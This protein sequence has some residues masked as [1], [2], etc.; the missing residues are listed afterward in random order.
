LE[1]IILLIMDLTDLEREFIRVYGLEKFDDIKNFMIDNEIFDIYL[2]KRDNERELLLFGIKFGIIEIV[3]VC[4]CRTDMFFD[5][6][7]IIFEFHDQ[8]KSFSINTSWDKFSDL[9]IN[10]IKYLIFL[11]KFSTRIYKYGVDYYKFN[12]KYEKYYDIYGN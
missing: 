4:Y 1:K 3:T 10:V 6:N 8:D 9:R 12:K 5:L 11:K 2:I 7:K